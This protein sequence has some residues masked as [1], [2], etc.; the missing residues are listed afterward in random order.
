[1]SEWVGK[2][3]SS[4]VYKSLVILSFCFALFLDNSLSMG[5][6]FAYIFMGMRC[7]N[8]GGNVVCL[9]YFVSGQLHVEMGSCM[10]YKF[11]KMR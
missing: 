11:I 10:Q 5:L 1:M 6:Y 7:H 8:G 3:V 4:I 2:K 9:F